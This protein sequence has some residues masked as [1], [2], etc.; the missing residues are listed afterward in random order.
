MDLHEYDVALEKHRV[1]RTADDAERLAGRFDKLI[2]INILLDGTY[3]IYETKKITDSKW[4]LRVAGRISQLTPKGEMFTPRVL[5]YHDYVGDFTDA[6]F[7]KVLTEEILSYNF[8]SGIVEER[9]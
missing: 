3:L 8:R 6:N 5:Q 9:Y 4:G 1:A 7:I 2:G